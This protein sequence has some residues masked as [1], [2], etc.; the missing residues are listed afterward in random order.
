MIDVGVVNDS[1]FRPG[2]KVVLAEGTYQGTP[3]V[4]LNLRDDVNWADIREYTGVVRSHPVIWLQRRSDGAAR[5][6][7]GG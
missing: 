5:L 3:G 1:G 2:D 6:Q 4:F 7:A